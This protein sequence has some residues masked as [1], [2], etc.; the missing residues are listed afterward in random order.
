MR[1]TS[2][3]NLVFHQHFRYASVNTSSSASWRRYARRTRPASLRHPL[4]KYLSHAQWLTIASAPPLNTQP[5]LS[6]EELV[7][8]QE[9][10]MKAKYGNLKPKKKL[11]HKVRARSAPE[12]TPNHSKRLPLNLSEPVATPLAGCQVLRLRGLRPSA[13]AGTS[14]DHSITASHPRRAVVDHRHSRC[15]VAP[16]LAGGPRASHRRAGGRRESADEDLVIAAQSEVIIV[17]QRT[18][19]TSQTSSLASWLAARRLKKCCNE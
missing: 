15:D 8:Q 9:E 6:E 4:E 18:L 2:V 13:F 3:E 17:F 12:L 14:S 19:P 1:T 10:K 7:R 11:I 5:Q 16:E